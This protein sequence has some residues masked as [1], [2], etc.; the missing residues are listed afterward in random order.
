MI[1]YRCNYIVKKTG[2][3][4]TLAT[5]SCYDVYALRYSYIAAPIS[6]TY[7]N[8]ILTPIQYY[9]VLRALT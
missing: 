1:T 8:I 2:F 6:T 7:Y 4:N 9:K 5:A 3:L